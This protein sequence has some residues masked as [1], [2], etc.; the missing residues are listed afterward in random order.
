M[1]TPETNVMAKAVAGH[2]YA[3][4]VGP[5]A[6]DLVTLRAVNLIKSADIIIT[7]RSAQTEVSMARQIIAP[8]L[9]NQEIIE[10]AYPM[11]RNLEKTL[12]AWGQVAEMI[13]ERSQR[14]QSIVQATLG[15]P[16]LYSTSCYLLDQLRPRLPASWIHIVPGISAMQT[17]AALGGE[18]LTL[19][20]DRMMLMTAHDL[21]EVEKALS[22]CETLV[23]YKCGKKI[24]ELASLLERHGLA[25]QAFLVCYAE[26]EGKQFMTQDLRAAAENKPGYLAT[27]IIHVGR[28][29]W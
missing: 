27:A 24:A 15:D 17:V 5:G 13:A 18:G 1:T 23:L 19:Q 9:Q 8:Y 12:Q 7:P 10:Q 11:E 4:G 14:G 26:Q 16:L 29:G 2:F 6:P 28:R 25:K 3:V 22:Y 20:E 21:N